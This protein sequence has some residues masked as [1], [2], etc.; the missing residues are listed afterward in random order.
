MQASADSIFE[1]LFLPIGIEVE[2]FHFACGTWS[3]AFENFDRARFAGSVWSEQP[4]DFPGMDLEIDAFNRF[5]VSVRLPQS[6][7]VDGKFVVCSHSNGTT[8]SEQ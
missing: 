7:H 5:D 2:H 1:L 3:Q 6:S 4:E 8:I